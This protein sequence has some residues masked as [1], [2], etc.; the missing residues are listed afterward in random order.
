M[1]PERE[2]I[3][4]ELKYVGSLNPLD[5]SKTFFKIGAQRAKRG[6]KRAKLGPKRAKAQIC[7]D[8]SRFGLAATANCWALMAV[9]Q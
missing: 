2:L 4:E 1:E 8:K 7:V 6:P 3:G 9:T 5:Q